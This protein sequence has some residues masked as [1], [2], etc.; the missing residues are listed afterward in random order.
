VY[1]WQGK[2]GNPGIQGSVGRLGEKVS[3][4]F[5]VFTKQINTSK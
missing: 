1:R 2:Q 3:S 4:F 5:A